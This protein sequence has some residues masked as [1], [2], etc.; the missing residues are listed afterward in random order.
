MDKT[1]DNRDEVIVDDDKLLEEL[2]ELEEKENNPEIEETEE[3]E[4]V[5]EKKKEVKEPEKPK[6]DYESKFK[7]S[8]QEAMV[9][10]AKLDEI[11]AEKN[12]PVVVDDE[13]MKANYPDWEDMTT[14]EQKLAKG[15]EETK[16]ANKEL[17]A[18]TNEYNNDRKWRDQIDEIVDDFEF[19]DKYPAIKG[20]EEEFK[21]F[22]TK[23]TRKG[24]EMDVLTAAFLFEYKEPEKELR[25]IFKNTDGGHDKVDP[26]R[27]LTLEESQTLRKASNSKFMEKLKDPK[28]DPLADL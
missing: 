3:F 1:I 5:E 10:K 22:C 11:E 8:S 14:T 16:Q 6:I 23:P 19:T 13:Y 24:V 15:L 7:A 25:T 18:K 27:G 28:Y 4:E 12:K 17:L 9:L 26:K 20:K 2:E 21:R